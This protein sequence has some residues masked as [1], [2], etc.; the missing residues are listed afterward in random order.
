[1]V[2]LFYLQHH[3]D[4]LEVAIWVKD[5]FKKGLLPKKI[6]FEPEKNG[7]GKWCKIF[8]VSIKH[9]PAKFVKVK[10]WDNDCMHSG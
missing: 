6:S 8:G 3:K 2:C 5:H 7:N 9:Y 4:Q 10:V 1:M